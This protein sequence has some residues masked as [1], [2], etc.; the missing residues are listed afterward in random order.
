[1]IAAALTF[2]TAFALQVGVI[3]SRLATD[4]MPVSAAAYLTVGHV[5]HKLVLDHLSEVID[6]PVLILGPDIADV[7]IA[8]HI[9]PTEH[10]NPAD[11]GSIERT[12]ALVQHA[13][14]IILAF[15]NAKERTEWAQFVRLIGIDAEIIEPELQ[16]IA[17]LG[18]HHWQGA[19]T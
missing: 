7:A 6:P 11:P 2:A 12:Y 8:D 10:R 1:V 3:Y 15:N 19:P 4:I 14:R 17:V 9:V 5:I 13:D 16:G 18:M